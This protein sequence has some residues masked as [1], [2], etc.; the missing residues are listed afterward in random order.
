MKVLIVTG[1]YPP[2]KCGVGD[3]SYS[4]AL[5]LSSNPD[6]K[7]GVLTSFG[8]VKED[9]VAPVKL[10]PIIKEWH[11]SETFTVTK[12]IKDWSPD[13]VHIQY[14]TQGYR[15][16]LLPYVI[17]IIS[18][19][20]RKKVVQTWHE[21]YS[22][23]QAP[24]LFMKA[25]IPGGLVIVRPQY[26]EKLHYMLRWGMRNKVVKFI[27]NASAIPRNSLSDHDRCLL[28]KQYLKKCKRLV[29]FFGFVYPHK[30]VDLLF[31]IANS[32]TDMLVIAGEFDKQ[33]DYGQEIMRYASSKPWV[34]HVNVPGFIPASDVAALLAVADAVILP[35][36]EGGG[37]W[38]TSIHGAVLQGVLVITTSKSLS[39]YD[40][41]RNVYYAKVDDVQEMRDALDAFAGIRREF[42]SDVDR[43][44]W[45]IIA[46]EHRALYRT[47]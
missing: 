37:Q 1:S 34:G 8:D 18:F 36:R 43:D 3:Y 29:V 12:L 40:K 44:E 42:S 11:L 30:G 13:I 22:R 9:T 38:N 33:S 10:F 14:P 19:I 26:K 7:I 21:G 45:E 31:K 4:L 35:F 28:R 2:M 47:I 6:F 15:D 16:G 32:D 23:R 5:A 46:N 17:P 25:V 39:G 27:P 24:K 41:N 20:L